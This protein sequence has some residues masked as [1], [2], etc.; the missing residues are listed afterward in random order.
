LTDDDCI[1]AIEE[2]EPGLVGWFNALDGMLHSFC[3]QFIKDST[4]SDFARFFFITGMYKAD[5]CRTAYL[6]LHGGYYFDVDVLG[7]FNLLL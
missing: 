7:E 4:C 6:Y 2:V 5:I 3:Y 1:N